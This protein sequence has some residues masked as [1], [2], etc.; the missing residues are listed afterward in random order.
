MKVG[1]IGCGYVGLVTGVGF[2]LKGH[3]VTSVEIDKSRVGQLT[4]GIVPFHEP[5]VQKGLKSVLK[6]GNI[7]ISSSMDDIADCEVILICVQTPPQP[8]GVI[9]LQ[10]LESATRNLVSVLEQSPRLRTVVVRSTVIPG[11][12]DKLVAP[13][14][15]GNSSAL[16]KKTAIAFN[17]EFLREGSA[18]QD[19]LNPDRIVIGTKSGMAK[20][21]L[22]KLFLPFKASIV[23]TTPS[24]A[25]LAKYASNTL[26]AT[27]ISFSN[28]IARVCERTPDTD[29]ED[30]LGVVHRDRRFS[31][32]E[33][34]GSLTAGILSYLKAGC[35]FGGS[36]LPKDLSAL[37]AYARSVDQETPLLQAVA[38]VNVG[39][40][41]RIIDMVS[42]ALGG[43]EKRKVAVLGV[44]FKGGTDDLRESPGLRIVDALLSKQAQVFIYDPLVKP[45]AL[46]G[47][48]NKR[49]TI[50]SKLME[51]LQYAD[52]C[53]VT[54]NSPEFK[55]LR[56]WMKQEKNNH[57]V[58]IDG[59]RILK[60]SGDLESNYYAIG[61]AR[62]P[63]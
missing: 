60:V 5:G 17:P 1:I 12:T 7:R 51:A 30:V 10:I 48:K 21:M 9:N 63:V 34:K 32:P 47:Y 33:G 38:T 25:E 26:L 42:K 49:V 4:K 50:A 3:K 40:S 45:V 58:I 54:S 11:T 6:Q 36:C 35:G 23:W 31:F 18:L 29:V 20:K 16:A 55:A 8:D 2:A 43:L 19:F 15:Q 39:Q 59:R 28:E 56:R 53:I 22:K 52:A 57:K 24:T 14:L 27:L 44:A 46:E 62:K 61:R 37:I 13:I 41:L